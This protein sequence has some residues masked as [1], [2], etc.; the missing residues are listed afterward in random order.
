[1]ETESEDVRGRSDRVEAPKFGNE[2]DGGMFGKLDGFG[3]TG[4]R[5]GDG[6]ASISCLEL[7]PRR[8]GLR[9]ARDLLSGDGALSFEPLFGRDS[10]V[11]SLLIPLAF[12]G[13]L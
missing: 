4:V 2:S 13:G 12:L 10:T 1:M 3:A 5:G 11:P 7:C 8:N 6:M 9:D